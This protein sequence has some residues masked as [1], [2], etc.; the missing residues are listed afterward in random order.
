MSDRPSIGPPAD[1]DTLIAML[2]QAAEL[3]HALSVQYLY[4][5]FTLKVGGDPGLTASQ[6]SLTQQWKQQIMKVAAQEMYHLMIA[7]NLLIAVG[8]PPNL[9]RPPFPQPGARYSDIDLPSVLTP[10]DLDTMSR[11]MCW[12][13]PDVESDPAPWWDDFCQKCSEKARQKYGL[14]AVEPPPYN[15][16]GELY[17]SIKQGFLD[18]PSWIDAGSADRQVTSE[19]VPFQ[20]PIA[21]VVKPQDAATYIDVIV[22]EGEGAPDWDSKSHFAYYHQIVNELQNITPETP[23]AAWPTVENPVYDPESAPPGTSVITD[24]AVAAVGTLFN[25]LYELLVCMLARLFSPNGDTPAQRRALANAPLALMPLGIKPIATL[26]T[27][28]PAGDSYPGLYAGP[29]FELPPTLDVPAGPADEALSVFYDSLES[30]A[31]RCYRL[32]LEETALGP[33]PMSQLAEHAARL[34]TMLPLLRP[35]PVTGEVIT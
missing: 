10:F 13:K 1:K 5:A 31:R 9:W 3:E 35:G 11:F 19:L 14:T 26:L 22:T 23:F 32:S 15:S 7:N 29:G 34:E 24:P 25:E 6:A 16:I 33:V 8:A 17:D 20:P 2:S 18:N 30:I 12:E 28:L 21:P 27:R 4:A